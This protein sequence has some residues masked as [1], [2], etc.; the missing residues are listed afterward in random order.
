[1]VEFY[2]DLF[3]ARFACCGYD[4]YFNQKSVCCQITIYDKRFYLGEK[5]AAVS[6]RT[7]LFRET[8][9]TVLGTPVTVGEPAR[10]VSLSTSFVDSFNLLGDTAGK[11]RLVSV[12]PSIDTGV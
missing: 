10:E 4:S 5:E 3:F 1:M 7:V 9:M 12:I 11:V 6:N 8:P 2:A